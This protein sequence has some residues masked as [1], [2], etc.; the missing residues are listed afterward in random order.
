MKTVKKEFSD[1]DI[2][3]YPL[4]KILSIIFRS[5]NMYLSN[6]L[7][8]TEINSG[9]FPFLINL[10]RRDHVTQKDLADEFSVSEGTVARAVKKL[11]DKDLIERKENPKNRR[12]KIITITDEGRDFASKVFDVDNRWEDE[13]L[14]HLSEDERLIFKKELLKVEENSTE[15]LKRFE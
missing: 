8:E 4:P 5:H 10:Y 6:L 3:E 12:E 9:E 13:I 15:I 14:N 1:R 7:K 11:E 2:M